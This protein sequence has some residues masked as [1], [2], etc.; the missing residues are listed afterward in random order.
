[1][2]IEEEATREDWINHFHLLSKE[3]QKKIDEWKNKEAAYQGTVHLLEH[4]LEALSHQVAKLQDE[5]DKCQIWH[6]NIVLNNNEEI[7]MLKKK[8]AD[9]E[10]S[11]NTM[12]NKDFRMFNIA[13]LEKC[14]VRN[15]DFS[16]F[17]P[18]SVIEKYHCAEF[19]G[20]KREYVCEEFFIFP[21]EVVKVTRI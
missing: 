3:T 21:T 8:L 20:R 17:N 12:T 19:T 4:K 1:M 9:T 11:I 15:Y 5:K 18:Q 7:R 14:I 13:D 2:I 10:T 6:N 16:T